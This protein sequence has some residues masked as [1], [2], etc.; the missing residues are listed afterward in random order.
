MACGPYYPYG[1]DVRFSLL[2]PSLFELNGY[3]AFIYSANGIPGYEPEAQQLGRAEN[4]ELWYQW[5]ECKASKEDIEKAVYQFDEY[6]DL[7][8]QNNSFL[9]YLSSKKAARAYLKFAQECSPFNRSLQDPW[10]R[11]EEDVDSR[12]QKRI[13]TAIKRMGEVQDLALKRRYA[14]L[15][16]RLAYYQGRADLV[17]SVWNQLFKGQQ[18]KDI[19]YHWSLYFKTELDPIDAQRN[20]QAAQVFVNAPDKRFKVRLSFDTNVPTDMVMELVENDQDRAAV[21]LIEGVGK[22]GKNLDAL[23]E[24]YRLAPDHPG[25]EFLLLREVNKLEDWIYTPYYTEF[26]PAMYPEDRPYPDNTSLMYQRL[27]GDRAYAKEVLAWVSSVKAKKRP[28]PLLWQMSKASLLH[29][30]ESPAK[31]LKVIKRIEK[32]GGMIL[33]SSIGCSK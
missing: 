16:I 12:R 27:Q 13:D 30:T 25:L 20:L 28:Q 29:M 23:K 22:Q 24:I 18:T 5:A 26:Y 31:A 11:E 19:L 3:E 6:P 9:A 33:A 1:E 21:W 8:E 17:S 15:A 32:K 10:E 4:I 2:D 7:N 14:F